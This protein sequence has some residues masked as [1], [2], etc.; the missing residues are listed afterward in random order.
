MSAGGEGDQRPAAAPAT[1]QPVAGSA[2]GGGR[3]NNGA[4]PVT[5][6]SDRQEGPARWRWGR[7]G[8]LGVLP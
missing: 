5:S 4:A 6:G 8:L 2:G 1:F 3:V 7:A